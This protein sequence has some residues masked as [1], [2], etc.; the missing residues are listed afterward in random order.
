MGYS[1]TGRAYNVLFPWCQYGER[2]STVLR[3]RL[4]SNLSCVGEIVIQLLVAG[5]RYPHTEIPPI[6]S[7]ILNGE[8]FRA[9]PCVSDSRASRGVI[10]RL[11]LLRNRFCRLDIIPKLR[12]FIVSGCVSCNSA[13][14][15]Q[16]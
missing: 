8:T 15:W 16:A 1:Q 3:N 10:A 7:L 4:R 12:A 14:F 5:K 11:R 2:I 13:N 9:G 6:Q